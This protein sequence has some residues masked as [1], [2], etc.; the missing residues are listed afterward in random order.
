V[1]AALHFVHARV[2]D[3]QQFLG[4]AAIVG[5]V[6]GPGAQAEEAGA[7][8]TGAA[9]T[10]QPVQFAHALGDGARLG[11]GQEKD[12]LIASHAGHAVALAAGLLQ[13]FGG[14]L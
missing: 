9:A 6:G 3:S 10:H 13:D 1:V 7:A 5:K 11:V 2:G 8:G 4:V 14:L 12:K